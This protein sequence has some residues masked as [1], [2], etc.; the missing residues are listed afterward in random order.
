V[1]IHCLLALALATGTLGLHAA[2][3]EQDARFQVFAEMSRPVAIT[4]VIDPSLQDQPARQTGLGVRFLGELAN[5]PG[6]YYEL[7]GKTNSTS[8]FTLNGPLGNGNSLDL[9]GVKFT[10][11][12]WSLGAAYMV[13]PWEPLTLGAHLEARGEALSAQGTVYQNLQGGGLSTLGTV[14]LSTTYLRPWVRLSGDLTFHMGEWR[15]Y[16]GVDVSGAITR[17]QQ[18]EFVSL[19][20][21]DGR[22]LRSLA[23]RFAAAFYVG[24]RF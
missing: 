8:R 6:W 24:A 20:L 16:V 9:T 7:G 13:H 11:S 10:D 23:P 18:T 3:L 21:M 4:V 14:G 5:A 2:D 15:P 12:Y 22:T 17:T 1:K 19:D